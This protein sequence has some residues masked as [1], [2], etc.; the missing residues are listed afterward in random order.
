MLGTPRYKERVRQA[1]EL[2][3]FSQ[4]E[5][6]GQALGIYQQLLQRIP[7]LLKKPFHL[8][9]PWKVETFTDTLLAQEQSSPR[10]TSSKNVLDCTDQPI[11]I[12]N[13][14]FLVPTLSL[15]LT[16]SENHFCLLTLFQ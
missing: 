15:K 11:A 8:E 1:A 16:K 4:L 3:A 9:S 7:R 5:T 10:V 2:N 13:T 12:A 6:Y 14:L